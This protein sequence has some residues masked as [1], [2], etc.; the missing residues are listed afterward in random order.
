MKH[1]NKSNCDV[2]FCPCDNC[3][4]KH[5]CIDECDFFRVYVVSL[6]MVRREANYTDFIKLQR[7]A[8]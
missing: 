5:H 6:T 7:M 3:R 4:F 8:G 1:T 2:S